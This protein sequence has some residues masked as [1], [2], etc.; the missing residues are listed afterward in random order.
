MS[1]D[2]SDLRSTIIPKSDQLNADQLLGGAMLITVT[3]V[4]LGSGEDQPVIVHYEN[5]NG[6]PFKPCKTMRK[7]LIH[8]W[9]KDGNAWA[10]RSMELYCDHAVKFGGESVGG[11]RI[12]RMSHI[13]KDIKVSLTATR[14]KKAMYEIKAL[15]VSQALHDALA[16]IGAATNNETLKKAKALASK[17]TDSDVEI[18]VT[19]YQAKVAALKAEAA[20]GI[21]SKRDTDPA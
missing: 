20:M 7:V 2:V 9:E 6:R 19:A 14:G 17:L 11:I 10:G 16:S 12:S 18:A 4:T 13:P 21:V 8:A 3:H 15:K 1:N 5:E